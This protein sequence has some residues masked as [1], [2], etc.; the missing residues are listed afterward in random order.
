MKKTI[1]PT[2]SAG[3]PA[4]LLQ[5]VERL[6]RPQRIS[7]YVVVMVVIAAL[8]GYFLLWPKYQQVDQL[9]QKLAA[10]QAELVKARKNAAELADWRSKMSDKE[11]EYKI[12]ARALPEKE[13]IP[14]LLAGI[15]QAGKDAGLEFLLFQPKPDVQKEFF[16]EIPVDISVTGNYH[17]VALFFE[18]VANLQRIVN[19]RD[20]KMTPLS[21]K[22]ERDD[23]LTTVCQAVTYKFVES[24]PEMAK[25]KAKA[26]K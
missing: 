13:E 2:G 11:S 19:I 5:K 6:S 3:A 18:K 9:Q 20:M 8:S 24:A 26:K 4:Q 7:I 12:V 22:E 25:G 14:T 23:K 1:Y 17:E 21:A 15:S 16:A 10:V